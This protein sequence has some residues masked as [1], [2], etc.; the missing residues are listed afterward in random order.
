MYQRSWNFFLFKAAYFM[1]NFRCFEARYEL[2]NIA[3]QH[4]QK[5][6]KEFIHVDKYN[7]V[8]WTL[9]NIRSIIRIYF[10][11][12]SKRFSC[13]FSARFAVLFKQKNAEKKSFSIIFTWKNFNHV[14]LFAWAE[15]NSVIAKGKTTF[16]W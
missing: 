15:R 9:K 16:V 7:I 3:R 4:P 13:S 14:F 8:S 5:G 2:Y 11:L 12:Y 1:L 10:A 6:W